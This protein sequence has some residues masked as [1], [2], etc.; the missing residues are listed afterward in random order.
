MTRMTKIGWP[1]QQMRSQELF[2]RYG[3]ADFAT[4]PP[5]LDGQG[6]DTVQQADT[7]TEEGRT[8]RRRK[9]KCERDVAALSYR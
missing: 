3:L 1:P 8:G 4:E 6:S 7:H 2:G 5:E 9:R